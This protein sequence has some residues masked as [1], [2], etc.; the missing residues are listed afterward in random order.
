LRWGDGGEKK[1]KTNNLNEAGQERWVGK[2][3][4]EG[5]VASGLGS[6]KKGIRNP[7]CERKAEGRLKKW[8]CKFVEHEESYKKAYAGG[9]QE[10][11]LEI[12]I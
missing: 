8:T 7:L 4:F 5:K 1:A 12:Q 6:Q 9:G 10:A 11:K 3:R 2:G